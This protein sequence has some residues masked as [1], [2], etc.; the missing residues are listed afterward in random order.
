MGT[1]IYEFIMPCTNCKNTMIIK[2][3][4]EKC[5]YL[6]ISGLTKY[7][8]IF[9][10]ILKQDDFQQEEDEVVKIQTP[11]EGE[12]MNKNP[13]L[14]METQKLDIIKSEKIRPVL[15]ELIKERVFFLSIKK[16]CRKF[17]KMIII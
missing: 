4:P 15:K 14:K 10:L 2:T 7:V 3:D 6:L 12:R 1:I 16:I 11:E 9:I 17:L 8:K 5:E 13:F